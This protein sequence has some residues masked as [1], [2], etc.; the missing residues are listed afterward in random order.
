MTRYAEMAT[1][2]FIAD[3]EIREVRAH[4]D[5]WGDDAIMVGITIEGTTTINGVKFESRI[6][7]PLD[8]LDRLG[9]QRFILPGQTL[10]LT[11][12]VR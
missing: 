9:D 5:G 7:V 11:A 2:I 1:S 6:Q 3:Y 8:E 12:E 4:R 10:T